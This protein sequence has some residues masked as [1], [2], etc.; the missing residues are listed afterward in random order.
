MADVRYRLSPSTT[1]ALV[2]A[3][4][5][6]IAGLLLSRPVLVALVAAPAVHLVVLLRQSPRGGAF[7]TRYSH[8]EPATSQ[9]PAQVYADLTPTPGASQALLRMH[10]RGYRT[11]WVLTG[12]REPIS[13]SLPIR[14]TGTNE[15]FAFDALPMGPLG[16]QVGD[17]QRV[18][19]I[20]VMIR[21]TPIPLALMPHSAQ[22][23]GLTGPHTSRRLGDGDEIRDVHPFQPGD[24]VKRIDWRVSARRGINPESGHIDELF[25]RRTYAV[26]EA[27]TVVVLDS[28][29]NVAGDVSTW[30]GLH[31]PSMD[32]PTSLDLAR[33]AASSIAR[34]A[35]EAGDRVGFEDLGRR[36]R[37][38]MPGTGRRHLLRINERILLASPQ[39]YVEA[40]VRPPNL[41]GGALVVLCSTLL[42]DSAPALAAQW[43]RR[44]H[45]VIVID[46]LP[47]PRT[48][49]LTTSQQR[50]AFRFVIAERT[51]R[52]RELGDQAITVLQWE[53]S[54]AAA[55]AGVAARS[56]RQRVRR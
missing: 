16:L 55:L 15:L 24:Q 35:I 17:H 40:I 39:A 1:M 52:L 6:A 50:L 37:P 36:S 5:L 12:A 19:P 43:Q 33:Q 26:A 22:L 11:S 7:T 4:V 3:L 38:V 45:E 25:V 49:L 23:R 41:A 29:D 47:T 34:G 13:V 10:T 48:E 46:T 51:L 27:I 32:E 20:A 14:R 56:R 8:T 2:V 54:P 53:D 31:L 18:E 42:D 30:A 21:P 44:G 28:R 9:S